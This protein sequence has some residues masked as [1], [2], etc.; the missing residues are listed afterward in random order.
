MIGIV[1]CMPPLE[2]SNYARGRLI[3]LVPSYVILVPVSGHSISINS[4]LF[5]MSKVY[6]ECDAVVPRIKLAC[7]FEV[8]VWDEPFEVVLYVVKVVCRDSHAGSPI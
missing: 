5:P 8:Y 7:F 4:R 6:N 1:V 2:V 3:F